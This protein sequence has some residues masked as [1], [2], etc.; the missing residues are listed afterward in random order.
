MKLPLKRIRRDDDTQPDRLNRDV[1]AGY[2]EM[3]RAGAVVELA[4]KIGFKE[5]APEP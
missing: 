1:V 4:R 2:A 5:V 3:M